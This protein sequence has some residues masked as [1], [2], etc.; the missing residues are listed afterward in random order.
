LYTVVPQYGFRRGYG[1]R[2]AIGA[3]RVLCGRSLEHNNKVFVCY[4][5]YEKAFDR[6]NWEKLMTVLKSIGV[7]W[8]DRRL[9]G[10]FIKDN[11]HQCRLGIVYQRHVK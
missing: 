8:R 11:R 5:D 1:T 10:I 3:M 4:V 9:I 2:D 6:V 7:D